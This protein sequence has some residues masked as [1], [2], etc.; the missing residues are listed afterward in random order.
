MARGLVWIRSG[1]AKATR[2]VTDHRAFFGDAVAEL[3][4]SID[5]VLRDI[6]LPVDQNNVAN[7]HRCLLFAGPGGAMLLD[8]FLVYFFANSSGVPNTKF[9]GSTSPGRRGRRATRA[10]RWPRLITSPCSLTI[11][12]PKVTIPVSRSLAS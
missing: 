1:H 3:D 11:S 7:W 12:I 10:E 8:G 9:H 5:L 6:L 2:P 4:P